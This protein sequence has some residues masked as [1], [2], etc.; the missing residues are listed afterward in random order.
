[1][2]YRIHTMSDLEPREWVLEAESIQHL[3]DEFFP[4]DEL[5]HDDGSYGKG[6]PG[7][8]GAVLFD[9]ELA[10]AWA[11]VEP[12][13]PS[14]PES[15]PVYKTSTTG[16]CVRQP[17]RLKRIERGQ[18]IYTART[19]MVLVALDPTSGLSWD[20]QVVAGTATY[21]PNGYKLSVGEEELKRGTLI[22]P[23]QLR[24]LVP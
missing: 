4:G 18:V 15:F 17:V 22:T 3:I 6:G 19:D 5:R 2:K 20:C 11:T 10:R 8:R 12:V 24:G 14:M 13:D 9:P 7:R 21:P 16:W 23:E 1:M